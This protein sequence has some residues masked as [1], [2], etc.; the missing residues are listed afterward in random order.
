MPGVPR[1]RGPKMKSPHS[2]VSVIL[3]ILFMPQSIKKGNH[4][5]TSDTLWKPR[6]A[7]NHLRW[8]CCVSPARAPP[9]S[10]ESA[11]VCK[12]TPRK[13]FPKSCLHLSP[14]LNPGSRPFMLAFLP[15]VEVFYFALS[16]VVSIG[17][18]YF[19]LC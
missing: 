1:S 2:K 4:K 16:Q 12:A 3:F 6:L 17:Y 7:A 10:P 18:L 14:P 8:Q 9:P 11:P 15:F 13:T 5:E 19:E